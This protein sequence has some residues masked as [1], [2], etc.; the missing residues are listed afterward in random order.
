M[1]V[2]ISYSSESLG[3]R[4][5]AI[6]EK[7]ISRAFKYEVDVFHDDLIKAGEDWNTTILNQVLESDFCVPLIDESYLDSPYTSFEIGA[8]FVN[9]KEDPQNRGNNRTRV[10][11]LLLEN[12]VR[13]KLET[14]KIWRNKKPSPLTIENIRRLFESI[15]D[16][17]I[18]VENPSEARRIGEI[19]REATRENLIE[20][21]F[22]DIKGA[23]LRES[24]SETENG[25]ETFLSHEL[26]NYLLR[27]YKKFEYIRRNPNPSESEKAL[28]FIL[29]TFQKLLSRNVI[30]EI[31]NLFDIIKYFDESF[32]QTSYDNPYL[33][34]LWEQYA[35]IIIR[36]T[37][38]YL[39]KTSRGEIPLYDS[40]IFRDFWINKIFVNAQGSIWTTNIRGT[41]GRKDN[42]HYLAQQKLAIE[43]GRLNQITRIFVYYLDDKEDF[44]QILQL[45][46]LQIKASITVGV[47]EEK[48]FKKDVKDVEKHLQSQDFMIIDDSFVYVTYVDH[49][50]K[51]IDRIE[52]SK[53]PDKLLY[54]EISRKSIMRD[55]VLLR[56]LEEFAKW[57]ASL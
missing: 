1:K 34:D 21:C 22:S 42:D 4:I 10:F 40:S 13:N 39:S 6:L 23:L 2:F 38:S 57:K 14:H 31:R 37:A 17:A 49:E 46:P 56:N 35:R 51:M 24:E 48:K 52:F 11:P 45:I 54:A 9:S 12:A 29:K 41:M 20:T 30:K 28:M 5:P 33:S 47:I 19:Y 26:P 53:D 27:N 36:K 55:T 7:H 44:K 43:S 8:F 50:Y 32:D 18:D 15:R 3:R 25:V 16:F